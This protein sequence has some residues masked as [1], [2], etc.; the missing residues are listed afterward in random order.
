MSRG[1][2]D[3][4]IDV[5]AGRMRWLKGAFSRGVSKYNRGFRWNG[6]GSFDRA[7]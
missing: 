7:G 3:E 4:V 1:T 6:D 5:I 2:G